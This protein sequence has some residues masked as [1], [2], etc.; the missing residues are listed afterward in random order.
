MNRPIAYRAWHLVEKTMYDV[1]QLEIPGHWP[2]SGTVWLRTDNRKEDYWRR[3]SMQE[4]GEP[5]L[6]VMEWSGLL[7]TKG[8]HIFEDDIVRDQEGRVHLVMFRDGAFQL[9]NGERI[10]SVEVIGNRWE[11]PEI[12]FPHQGSCVK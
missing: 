6:E 3:V 12:Q 5:L 8:Y 9:D 4:K 2:Q 1:Q 11:D 10:G 7:D